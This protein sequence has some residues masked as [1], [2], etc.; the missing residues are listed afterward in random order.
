MQ[1]RQSTTWTFAAVL[2]IAATALTACGGSDGD[3][4]GGA[5]KA[6]PRVLTMAAPSGGKGQMTVF[7]DEVRRLSEGTLEIRFKERWRVGEP[8][9]EAGTLE[10]VKAGEVDMAWVG[11]RAFDTVGVKSF[12][13]LLAP[14]LVDSYALEAK[15]FEEGIPNEMLETVENLDLVGIG[16]LPGPMRKM[17]GVSRPF[18]EAADFAGQVVGIQDSAVAKQTLDAVGSAP[19]RRSTVS[20]LTSSSWRRSRQTPMTR[21]RST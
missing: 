11:A 9:Y 4:A 18:V 5:D 17:L 13:A 7:A 6:N 21:T 1:T 15:V 8:L 16:V 10:D 20:T 12:Q 2:A 19:R 14:L 3:K